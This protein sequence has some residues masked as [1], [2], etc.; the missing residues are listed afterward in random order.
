M[1]LII[2]AISQGLLWGILALGLFITYR[3]L[4]IADL[5]AEGSFPLGAAVGSQLLIK[6][7]NPLLSAGVA[8]L[9][10]TLAGAVT[11]VLITKG[12]IPGL[13]AGI[14]TMTGLYSI[15]LRVMNRANVSLLGQRRIVDLLPLEN[16]SV[17]FKTILLA[18]I[19]TALLVLLLTLFF[20]TEV[21]Q[22]VIATGDNE[23]MARSLGI[24]TDRMTF[25]GLMISNGIVAFGGAM[26]AQDNGYADIGM[27]IGTIVIGLASIIIGEVLFQELSFSG[28]LMSIAIGSIAYRLILVAVIAAGLDPNDLRLISAIILAVFLMVPQLKSAHS[29]RIARKGGASHGTGKTS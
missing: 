29:E 8:F 24:Y 12:R 7:M 9:A 23:K 11:G 15:N 1:D 25:I 17:E 21:G 19:L 10:G 14:L 28:R 26:I 3:I 5:T 18:I 2:N 4:D 6:G 16:V 22:A 27:G 20:H 13:L